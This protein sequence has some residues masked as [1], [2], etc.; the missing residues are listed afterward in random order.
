[1][2]RVRICPPFWELDEE[3]KGVTLV[4]ESS[5]FLDNGLALDYKYGGDA[6]KRLA[7]EDPDKA[8]ANADSFAFFAWNKEGLE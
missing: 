2:L 7:K 1:M 4:H 5:H 8:V 3:E 6:C